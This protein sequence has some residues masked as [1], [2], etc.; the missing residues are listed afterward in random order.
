V[1]RTRPFTFLPA[2][3]KGITLDDLA[4]FLVEARA[5]GVPG[6]AY[7]RTMGAVD[8]AS[9]RNMGANGPRCARLTAVPEEVSTDA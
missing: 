5:N 6:S 4:A 9:L 8:G 7:V 2:D 1:T 3:G